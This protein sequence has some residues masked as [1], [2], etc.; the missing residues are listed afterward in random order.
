MPNASGSY[1][2]LIDEI[3]LDCE[4]L[5]ILYGLN[6]FDF[7]FMY[8]GAMLLIVLEMQF[9]LLFS[10]NMLFRVCFVLCKIW[11]PFFHVD[12]YYQVLA[13]LMIS[14][15]SWSNKHNIMKYLNKSHKFN[16]CSCKEQ[17]EYCQHTGIFTCI[18]CLWWW[19]LLLLEDLHYIVTCLFVYSQWLVAAGY[20]FYYCLSNNQ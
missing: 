20:Y 19:F 2:R 11:S 6:Y 3:L 5:K 1:G 18:F 9:S 16:H 4:I 13:Y 17:Q 8:S 7:Y 14:T 12:L 15:I 10:N